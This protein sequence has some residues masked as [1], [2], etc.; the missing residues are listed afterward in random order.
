MNVGIREQL[1]I[2]AGAGMALAGMRPIVHTF[3]SFLVERPFEQ[4]KLDFVHQ[5]VGG[6]LVGSGGSL[7]IAGGGRTHQSPG[8][9]ALLDTLPGLTVMAPAS[10][11][12]VDEALRRAAAASG[13][14]YVRIV[15]QTN[16]ESFPVVPRLH[17][18]KRG[19]RATVVSL[20]PVLGDVLAATA[21]LDVTVLHANVVRP[22]DA[23]GLRHAMAGTDPDVAV[24]EPWL[25]GTSAHVISQALR[26]RP[27]RLLSIGVSR[28]ELRRYGHRRNTSRRAAWTRTVSALA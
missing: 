9:V 28:E 18:V 22:F 4:I 25:E 7:D 27:H 11:S 2:S 19:S 3:G 8:D 5:G 1:L 15:E 23:E 20:G 14:F 17:L 16:Q 6:V 13:L 12:E 26:D 24:V 10:A 21:D